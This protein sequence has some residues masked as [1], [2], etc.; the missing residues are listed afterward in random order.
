MRSSRSRIDLTLRQSLTTLARYAW[1]APA[2][3]AGVCL[4]VAALAIGAR[5]RIVDG[6]VEVAGGRIA[7]CIAWLPRRCRFTAITFGHMIIGCDHE[8]LSAFRR[9][10]HVHVR[11]YE[12]WGVLFFPLYIGS[13]LVQLMLH[14]DPY[15]DN[16]FEREARAQSGE[17]RW[18]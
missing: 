1:A 12:R 11:Q 18:N 9:H 7:R 5:P 4:S 8:A 17:G 14:R 10:E 2:T 13:S 3:L 6:C 15:G 16:R